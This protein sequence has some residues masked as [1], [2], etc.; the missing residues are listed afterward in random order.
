MWIFT[1]TGFI[2]VVSDGKELVVRSRDRL[3]LEPLSSFTKATI[4]KTPTSDYP[5]RLTLSRQG[6]ADWLS[7]TALGIDYRNYKSEVSETR[8]VDFAHPLMD[9][10]SVMHEVEDADARNRSSST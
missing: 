9:V 7:M 6:F 2:S 10:W 8:G 3:S 5:Y 4:K 1:N